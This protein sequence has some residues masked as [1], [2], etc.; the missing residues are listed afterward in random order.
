MTIL[1]PM[2]E[3]DGLVPDSGVAEFPFGIPE[4]LVA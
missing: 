4:L 2:I 3:T 1:R